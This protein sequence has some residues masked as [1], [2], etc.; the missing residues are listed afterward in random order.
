MDGYTCSLTIYS[1]IYSPTSS[2]TILPRRRPFG[3]NWSF[4]ATNI[5]D[6]CLNGQYNTTIKGTH[7]IF[8]KIEI[9]PGTKE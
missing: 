7:T 3:S 6:L 4:E 8:K 2:L 1:P 5:V 9:R